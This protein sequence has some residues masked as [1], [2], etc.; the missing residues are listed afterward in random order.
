MEG[1]HFDRIFKLHES[2]CSIISA[3]SDKIKYLLPYLKISETLWVSLDKDQ[4]ES[5]NS[6]VISFDKN[7]AN[8]ELIYLF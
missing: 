5:H 4:M 2:K 7:D 3:G 1:D 6:K 8:N